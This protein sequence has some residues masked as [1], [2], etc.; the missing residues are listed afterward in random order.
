M[1]KVRDFVRTVDVTDIHINLKEMEDWLSLSDN[2]SKRRIE[3]A[4]RK[5]RNVMLRDL[6]F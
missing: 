2:I 3:I 1:G 4:A 5:K 6:R